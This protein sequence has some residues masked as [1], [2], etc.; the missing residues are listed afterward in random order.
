MQGV[1]GGDGGGII[2]GAQ[3]EI[4]WAS[5]RG[6]MDMENLG[7][8]G[9][10]ADVPHGLTGQGR[11]VELPGGGISRIRGDKDGDAGTFYAPECP[12]HHGNFKVGKNTPTTVPPIR[13]DGTLAYTEHKAPC[14]RTVRQESRA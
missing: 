1:R 3:D 6:E 4:S 12:G 5:G 13:H 7:H 2:V 8:G 10:A 9:R 11:P 14:H